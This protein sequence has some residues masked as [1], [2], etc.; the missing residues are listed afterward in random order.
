MSVSFILSAHVVYAILIAAVTIVFIV[1]LSK[2]LHDRRENAYYGD[3]IGD[4]QP[5]AKD[6]R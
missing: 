4:D 1:Q 2:L 6:G 3:R 5:E